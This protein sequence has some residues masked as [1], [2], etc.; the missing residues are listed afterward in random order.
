MC[1][2]AAFHCDFFNKW[3]KRLLPLAITQRDDLYSIGTKS[4]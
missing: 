4:P 1:P 3:R 2:L